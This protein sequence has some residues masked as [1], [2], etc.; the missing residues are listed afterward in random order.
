[1]LLWLRS[2]PVEQIVLGTCEVNVVIWL[3]FLQAFPCLAQHCIVYLWPK[4][5]PAEHTFFTYIKTTDE[6]GT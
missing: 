3:Q 4:K 6:A 2:V 1:M 5:D